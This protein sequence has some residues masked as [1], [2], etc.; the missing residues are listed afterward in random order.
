MTHRNR[1]SIALLAC[2][3]TATLLTGCT[4]ESPE[5]GRPNTAPPTASPSGN[6]LPSESTA[7]TPTPTGPPTRPADADGLSLAAA[8]A[9]VRHYVDL[10]NYAS[11]TGD[12]GPLLA[13]SEAGCEGC[14]Q[15]ADFAAKVNAANG[16]LSGD[17]FERVSEVSGLVRGSS[18]HLRGSAAVTIGSYTTKGSASAAPVTS[19]ATS[20]T[21]QVALS[22]S[23]GNW[24]MFEIKLEERRS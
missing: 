20:Y 19:K 22:P 16:G 11:Q 2:L 24:I 14:K 21:E 8:E 1:P 6:P 4:Q 18:G 10:M 3:A 5:A 7:A 12:G 17:Y 13:A 15:Y 9:F 23:K